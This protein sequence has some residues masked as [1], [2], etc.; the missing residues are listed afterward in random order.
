MAMDGKDAGS[1]NANMVSLGRA[2]KDWPTP[3]AN[4]HKGSAAAGQRRGQLDE[5]SEQKWATP[6]VQMANGT[7]ERFLERKRESV[8]RGNTMGVSLSDLNMQTQAWT[9]PS[10]L[11]D[12]AAV[13]SG[14]ES[15]ESAQTSRPRLNPAFVE[16]MMGLPHGWTDFAPAGMAWCHWRRRMRLCLFGLV[17][18][19]EE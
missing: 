6:V 16:W 15:C 12:Q 17:S 5:A 19:T 11:P 9:Y 14:S 7:P 1:V 2:T 4:D 8:A 18:R 3:G 10:S 13:L